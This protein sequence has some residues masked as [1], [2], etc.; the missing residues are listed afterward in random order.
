MRRKG[1]GAGSC[2]GFTVL[3]TVIVGLLIFYYALFGALRSYR[4][5]NP[6]SASGECVGWGAQMG[7]RS[8]RGRGGCTRARGERQCCVCGDVA[9][10]GC[11]SVL[12]CAGLRRRRAASVSGNLPLGSTHARATEMVCK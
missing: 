10:L 8:G 2:Y 7:W 12:E 9:H 3:A 6:D 5:N 1:L 11:K 4:E